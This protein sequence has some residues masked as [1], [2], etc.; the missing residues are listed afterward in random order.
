MNADLDPDDATPFGRISHLDYLLTPHSVL[1][2]AH[3][4][5]VPRISDVSPFLYAIA[6][7]LDSMFGLIAPNLQTEYSHLCSARGYHSE[8]VTTCK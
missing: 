3:D 1:I 7:F 2:H 6:P 5:P 4:L 8:S